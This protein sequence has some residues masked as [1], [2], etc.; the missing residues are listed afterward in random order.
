MSLTETESV[1]L[2]GMKYNDS[3]KIVSLY[4]KD[5]GKFN[6]LI[7]GVR[8]TRSGQCGNYEDFNYI[9]IFFNY[10]SNRELQVINKSE[11]LDTYQNIKTDLKKLEPAY[12]ILGIINKLNHEYDANSKVFELLVN[13]LLYLNGN[14]QNNIS[15]YVYFL[16][17][18]IELSGISLKPNPDKIQ[19]TEG[20]VSETFNGDFG[21]NSNKELYIQK[22][23]RMFEK[24][25]EN[26]NNFN[27]EVP[28]LENI[29]SYLDN[30]IDYNF[31]IKNIYI[32]K[33]IFKK[34]NENL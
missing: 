21:L 29:R 23:N 27:L 24:G 8:S 22:L 30:Y 25:I 11:C 1:V 12:I 2:K 16:I 26:I 33:Y 6:A 17:N 13:S 34:I 32:S 28:E 14:L 9:K 31:D 3:S 18:F 5:F 4:T 15:V 7:K 19:R 20:K 10:K